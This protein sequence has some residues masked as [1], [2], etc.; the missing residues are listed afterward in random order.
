MKL[1]RLWLWLFNAP[2]TAA[3]VNMDRCQ[4]CQHQLVHQWFLYFLQT[5]HSPGRSPKWSN[6]YRI[7]HEEVSDWST[8]CLMMIV[9]CKINPEQIVTTPVSLSRD[10]CIVK[11]VSRPI[12]PGLISHDSLYNYAQTEKVFENIHQPR[13]SIV[14]PTIMHS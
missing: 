2:V 1:F 4:Q 5:Q 14:P 10:K 12:T 9:T 8:D 13:I 3:Q 11:T 6:L 7:K